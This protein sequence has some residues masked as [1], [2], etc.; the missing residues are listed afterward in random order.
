MNFRH[1]LVIIILMILAFSLQ[2]LK[3]FE[4]VLNKLEKNRI[5]YIKKPFLFDL[6]TVKY[7]GIDGQLSSATEASLWRVK[8]KAKGK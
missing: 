7:T 8:S 2:L 1:W 5:Q 6:F 4:T 3:D